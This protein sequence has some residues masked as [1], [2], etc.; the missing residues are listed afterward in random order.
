MSEP[1]RRMGVPVSQVCLDLFNPGMTNEDVDE[2]FGQLAA[3]WPDLMQRLYEKEK[4]TPP[5]LTITQ[6][7]PAAAQLRLFAKIQEA[8][9]EA[10]GWDKETLARA[11]V[12]IDLSTAQTGFSW[13]SEKNI[14]LA[15]ETY[16]HDLLKGLANAMHECGHMLYTLEMNRLPESVLG[17]PVAHPNGTAKNESAALY[18]ERVGLQK[19]FFALVAPLIQQELG[20]S[21]PE[22]EA[23][24]LHRFATRHDLT[25]TGW[26]IS[27]AML[28]P[29]MAWRALAERR[30]LDG[31]MSVSELPEFWARTMEQFTGVPHDPEQFIVGEDHWPGGLTGY[32]YA[33]QSG[34]MDA[35]ALHE[36]IVPDSGAASLRDYLQ[37]YYEHIGGGVFSR[38]S[39][40]A[41]ESLLDADSY[42]EK[43]NAE[44][45]PASPVPSPFR[46][47]PN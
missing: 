15:I 18:F 38:G 36:D 31:E 44:A 37:P 16:P 9:L 5:P 26:G 27:E 24:N 33:Y 28:A 40:E 6:E 30:I 19:E 12:T 1:S 3:G 25:D 41:P 35:V 10:A 7:I 2:T 42:L 29:N 47:H 4:A 46:P 22:W 20:V 8:M 23:G 11:G 34:A 17:T 14:K 45:S 21:G 13:G 39:R 43:L 32:F